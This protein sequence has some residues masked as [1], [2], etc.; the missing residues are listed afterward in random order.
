LDQNRISELSAGLFVGCKKLEKLY[1]YLKLPYSLLLCFEDIYKGIAFQR[2]PRLCLKTVHFLLMCKWIRFLFL[3][4]YFL[5]YLGQNPLSWPLDKLFNKFPNF[6]HQFWSQLS[7]VEEKD[8]ENTFRFESIATLMVKFSHLNQDQRH[9]LDKALRHCDTIQLFSEY[10]TLLNDYQSIYNQLDESLLQR[11]K[12]LCE[13]LNPPSSTPPMQ[14]SFSIDELFA[15]AREAIVQ[16]PQVMVGIASCLN[17]INEEEKDMGNVL[18]AEVRNLMLNPGDGAFL[19]M[20]EIDNLQFKLQELKSWMSR[21]ASPNEV[22]LPN[23]VHIGPLKDV[24]RSVEKIVREYGGNHNRLIDI[25]RGSILCPDI[26]SLLRILNYLRNY[27]GD[28]FQLVRIK[29]GFTDSLMAGGYRDIKCNIRVA[30][31][32]CEVQFHLDSFYKLKEM[33]GHDLYNEVRQF[34]VQGVLSAADLLMG[35][36]KD[37]YD[38]LECIM[39][40]DIETGKM[41]TTLQN[42]GDPFNFKAKSQT[43]SLLSDLAKYGDVTNVPKLLSIIR[44]RLHLLRLRNSENIGQEVAI[45]NALKNPQLLVELLDYAVACQNNGSF[46]TAIGAFGTIIENHLAY[47]GRKHPNFLLTLREYCSLLCTLGFIENGRTIIMNVAR[48]YAN[49]LGKNSIETLR[50]KA[51]TA[52]FV[53][54]TEEATTILQQVLTE[55]QTIF[56]T[57]SKHLEIAASHF[58]LAKCLLNSVDMKD[59]EEA[60]LHFIICRDVYKSSFSDEDSRVLLINLYLSQARGNELICE[61]TLLM[62]ERGKRRGFLGVSLWIMAV[63]KT[64]LIQSTNHDQAWQYLCYLFEEVRINRALLH[65]N[66]FKEKFRSLKFVEEMTESSVTSTIPSQFLLR[67][68]ETKSSIELCQLWLFIAV[69]HESNYQGDLKWT[70]LNVSLGWLCFSEI[71]LHH[72]LLSGRNGFLDGYKL[73]LG[74]S[75]KFDPL[76]KSLITDLDVYFSVPLKHSYLPLDH[77]AHLYVETSSDFYANG[78]RDLPS[79]VLIQI[80]GRETIQFFLDVDFSITVFQLKQVIL[81]RQGIPVELQG[82]NYGG[83]RLENA[84]TLLSCGIDRGRRVLD[85]VRR[86]PAN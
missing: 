1:F 2:F 68:S 27:D 65:R 61:L 75:E 44:E 49:I 6:Q 10:N 46:A 29:N 57:N 72:Y 45:E 80:W 19:S 60:K 62:F 39:R 8:L 86:W 21:R 51:L 13:D 25:V 69:C 18:M 71:R 40:L 33:R 3:C 70:P 66:A 17:H 22:Q 37:F 28:L 73:H 43:L 26:E 52:D 41:K 31:H 47:F 77:S 81:D 4:K 14:N 63:I 50:C 79:R 85:C 54:S 42:S 30:G 24:K 84:E 35:E 74:E 34:Q 20:Q 9:L 59:Q 76:V 15:S 78:G 12:V 48:E 23:F 38:C 11:L 83:K 55:N 64:F 53:N 32:I 5:R 7:A 16:F 82:L 56:G 67:F 58:R 36:S